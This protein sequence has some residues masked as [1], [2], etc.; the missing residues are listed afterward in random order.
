[1]RLEDKQYQKYAKQRNKMNSMFISDRGYAKASAKAEKAEGK[2]A[3]TRAK[4]MRFEDRAAGAT[5]SVKRLERKAQKQRAKASRVAHKM[6]K[7][8]K[9]GKDYGSNQESRRM[10][11]KY[12]K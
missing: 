9:R 1:M 5:E 6:A 2:Y 7:L 3:K 11:K 10:V 8:S 12:S 4:R